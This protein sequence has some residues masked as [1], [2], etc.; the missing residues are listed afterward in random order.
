MTYGAESGKY[1]MRGA[2]GV[3]PVTQTTAPA[4]QMPGGRG[5]DGERVGLRVLDDV[6]VVL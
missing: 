3:R 5:K 2:R 4:E 1:E 6:S